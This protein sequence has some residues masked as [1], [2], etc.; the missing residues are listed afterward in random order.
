MPRRKKI[1][2]ERTLNETIELIKGKI[3]DESKI[4]ILSRG[5]LRGKVL[6]ELIEKTKFL[7][8]LYKGKN[9]QPFHRLWCVMNNIKTTDDI[10]ICVI[11]NQNHVLLNE[12]GGGFKN[13]C[14]QKCASKYGI[15]NMTPEQ[16]EAARIKRENTCLEIY[17]AKHASQ[18][19]EVKQKVKETQIKNYGSLEAAKENRVNKIR[20]TML[21]EY[22][23]DNAS[24]LDW[25]KDKKKETSLEHYGTEYPWQ[26]EKGK[27]EQKQG[28]I[29]KYGV[30]NV[31]KVPEVQKKKEET[32][33][34]HYGK[35]NIFATEEFIFN[36]KMYWIIMY[37]VGNPSDLPWVQDK[38][39]ETCQQ[40]FGVD[41]Y[42]Q[43]E[44]FI[45]ENR[46]NMKNKC[47]SR[48]N[49]GLQQVP[50]YTSKACK[51]IDEIGKKYGY[52]FQHAENGGEHQVES[53]FLDGYDIDKN[54]GIEIDEPNH[55]DS[56]GNL[57][58]KD[59][60]R[61]ERIQYLLGCTFIRIKVKDYEK[62]NS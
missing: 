51:I 57:K 31:S 42:F 5:F 8:E 15:T 48:K 24:K 4:A 2:V 37:G 30:D 21:D 39:I 6:E 20:Q 49:N 27:E 17:G 7:D 28:V 36:N 33:M 55:Y 23:T 34:E 40:H 38:K 9:I 35:S 46:K 52:N 62:Q 22:G 16:K 44:K 58:P 12:V 59:V 1:R 13:T 25:V 14:S 50:N 43:Y 11:C 54:I 19:D 29:N 32:F 53:Y 18:V 56:L 47:E 41:Y 60:E 45:E 10:P 61:Q 3:K 26:S